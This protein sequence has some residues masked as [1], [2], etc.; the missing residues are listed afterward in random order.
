MACTVWAIAQARFVDVLLPVLVR[1][2]RIYFRKD[3]DHDE[4]IAETV[5][6]AWKW[7][8]RLL[9]RRKDPCQWPSAF[10]GYATRAVRSG[11][12]ACGHERVK[13]VMSPNAQQRHRF[14]CGK[15]P[16]FST[17]NTNPLA[18]ALTDNCRSP[19]PDQVQFRVDFPDWTR[20]RTERDRRLIGDMATGERTKHLA[21]KYRL[22]PARVSQLRR[23]YHGD[24]ELFC[25]PPHLV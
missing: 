2:A 6:L 16:D 5:A 21:R 1:H 4:R 13:D 11:R 19:V 24:W 22:S 9:Q 3:R 14:Y 10:A 17:L 25:E 8:V 23:E 7:Y 20:T 18:E 12:R 15:L